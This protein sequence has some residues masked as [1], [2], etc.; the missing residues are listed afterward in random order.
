[1]VCGLVQGHYC[2]TGCTL[3]AAVCP[4]SLEPYDFTYQATGPRVG[5]NVRISRK[6]GVPTDCFPSASL[7]ISCFRTSNR[8]SIVYLFHGDHSPVKSILKNDLYCFNTSYSTDKALLS[9]CR[10][11]WYR[12]TVYQLGS[13][14]CEYELCSQLRGRVRLPRYSFGRK[15]RI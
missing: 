1:M 3:V 10:L 13:V 6:A 2:S 15:S 9:I 4:S 7:R 8:R 11:S 12:K 5:R 14:G